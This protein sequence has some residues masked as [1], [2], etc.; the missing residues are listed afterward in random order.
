MRV[1]K[2][3]AAGVLQW[4]LNPPGFAGLLTW[5]TSTS[6][7]N[8]LVTGT[9][10]QSGADSLY[11]VKVSSAGTV[12]WDTA[13]SNGPTNNIGNRCQ[14]TSDGGYFISGISYSSQYLIKIGPGEEPLAVNASPGEK[15]L[16]IYP[17]PVDD[18]LNFSIFA[19]GKIDMELCD[20]S[21]RNVAR[22]TKECIP[23]EQRIMLDV[24][25]V[26]EG[27]YLL[28]VRTATG[29]YMQQVVVHRHN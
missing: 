5:I 10:T 2:A 21:G 22:F 14:E 13:F 27:L 12:I 15:G 1:L 9:K 25:G 23:G 28:S 19:Q 20:V 26:A 7:G 29:L 24:S 18:E 11:L 8:Y 17:N 3:N 6:D 16:N 4:V